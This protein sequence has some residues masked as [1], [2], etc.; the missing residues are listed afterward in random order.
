MTNQQI[1]QQVLEAAA[2]LHQ[3]ATAWLNANEKG[4]DVAI[5]LGEASSAMYETLHEH[6]QV[7]G[8]DQ[9][10]GA[11]HYAFDEIGDSYVDE[12]NDRQVANELSYRSQQQG[13]I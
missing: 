11:C 2:A 13:S 5:S 6:S 9:P 8:S 7:M 12:L 1:V 3:A 4:G 10:E